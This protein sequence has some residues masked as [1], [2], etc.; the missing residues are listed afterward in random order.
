MNDLNWHIKKYNRHHLYT[1]IENCTGQVIWYVLRY[2][3]ADTLA[4]Q[5]HLTEIII[6]SNIKKIIENEIN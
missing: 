5:H 6:L 3:L 1:D 2:S 4:R